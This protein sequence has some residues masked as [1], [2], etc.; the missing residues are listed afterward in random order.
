MTQLH[1]TKGSTAYFFVVIFIVFEK[2]SKSQI[3]YLFVF[4][5]QMG[6]NLFEI[7]A[8]IASEKKWTNA[9]DKSLL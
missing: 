6:Q 3:I 5:F 1:L 9:V 8:Q 4:C 7:S 2:V